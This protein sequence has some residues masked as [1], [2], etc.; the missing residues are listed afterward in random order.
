VSLLQERM[1]HPTNLGAPVGTNHSG[2]VGNPACGD[3]LTMYLRI[4]DGR[5]EAA[6]FESM[7]TAYGVATASVLCDCITGQTPDEA[8]AR[9]P[10][11]VLEKLPDLPERHRYLARLAIDSL[12]LALRQDG[13]LPRPDGGAVDTD[14]AR[15]FVRRV[16][17]NG[18]R[19]TTQQVVAMADAEAIILPDAP[20]RFL[21]DMAK[22]G[23]IQCE[24]D[25]ERKS[26][27]WFL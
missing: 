26:M 12:R 1:R 20:A 27:V 8:R 9:G 24:M 21:A 3:V 15:S 2:A 23:L 6:G 19:W 13:A 17:G 18:K 25:V 22:R 14:G 11:C 5:I 7:G 10:A 4:V 16:V